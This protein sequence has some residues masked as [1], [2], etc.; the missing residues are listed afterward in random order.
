V[1]GRV[2]VIWS[3]TSLSK[4]WQKVA[5]FKGAEYFRKALYTVFKRSEKN[6]G[7]SSKMRELDQGQ[8]RQRSQN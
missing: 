1:S 8:D 4:H 5:K 2:D 3:L 7:S 6:K